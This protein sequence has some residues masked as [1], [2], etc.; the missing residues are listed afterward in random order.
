VDR[1]IQAADA[2]R[3]PPWSGDDPH[4]LFLVKPEW[5]VRGF[6]RNGWY[7]KEWNNMEHVVIIGTGCA[8]LTAATY[9]A[10]A[11]LNPLIHRGWTCG[12]TV[13]TTR[14]SRTTRVF[15]R[16]IDGPVLMQRMREQAVRFG[17]RIE[18][19]WSRRLMSKPVPSN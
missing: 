18:R 17:V 2:P 4:L 10:R 8:G 12:R 16:V 9:T 3:F 19:D 6:R 14:W 7:A 5:L 15:P 13:G 11:N 1:V